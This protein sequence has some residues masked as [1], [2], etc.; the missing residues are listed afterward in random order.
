MELTGLD[1]FEIQHE[2]NPIIKKLKIDL[3]NVDMH[4]IRKI[5]GQ[6][7]KHTLEKRLKSVAGDEHLKAPTNYNHN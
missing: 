4:D 5:V 2:L 1:Q 6:Y 3:N 7:L